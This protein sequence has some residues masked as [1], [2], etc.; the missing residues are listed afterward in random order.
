[1]QSLPDFRFLL[2]LF[3]TGSS[4]LGLFSW[5]MVAPSSG[6]CQRCC[7]THRQTVSSR[8]RCWAEVFCHLDFLGTGRGFAGVGEGESNSTGDASSCPFTLFVRSK[9]IVIIMS[10]PKLTTVSV[11]LA[12]SLMSKSL[13][14]T[15]ETLAFVA[16]FLGDLVWTVAAPLSFFPRSLWFRRHV[17]KVREKRDAGPATVTLRS[18]VRLPR[19]KHHQADD[20]FAVQQAKREWQGHV[21]PF[22]NPQHFTLLAKWRQMWQLANKCC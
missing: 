16:T 10:K 4:S 18:E 15:A 11:S 17:C 21:T 1:M 9:S 13:W 8:S 3:T 22:G 6:I 2:F 19:G 20:K 7:S 14:V 12:A 5:D